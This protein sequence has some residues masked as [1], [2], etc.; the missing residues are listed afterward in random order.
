M[1]NTPETVITMLATSSLG[2]S[3]PPPAR[4]SDLPGCS[5]GS[6][7][8]LPKCLWQQTVMFYAGRRHDRREALQQIVAELPS[9]RQVYL[10][11]ELESGSP[12]DLRVPT[13]DFHDLLSGSG[14]TDGGFTQMP[15]DA[16]GFVLYPRV[17]PVCPSAWSTEVPVCCSNT[18]ASIA[19]TSTCARRSGVLVH[20]LRLDDVELAVSALAAGATVVLYDGSPFHPGPDHLW[21]I[22]EQEQIT[23]FGVSAK[24][25][26]AC[27]KQ[28][29]KPG[30]DRD[31]SSLRTIGSTGSPLSPEAFAY[32]YREVK[33][34]LHL[35]SI[36]GGTD[37]CGCFALGD[38]TSR[39]GPVNCRRQRSARTWTSWTKTETVCAAGRRHRGVDLPQRAAEYAP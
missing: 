2:P 1:P 37:I 6:G 34:D 16:P 25:L 12:V 38:P 32:V 35:A 29:L 14:T 31:L 5:T 4:T 36:S 19:G 28:G 15:F 8:S 17:P 20:H 21:R 3:S 13:H 7:R 11:G 33:P 10:V 26:D 9:V 30:E 24:Y 27:H 39:S 23:L 18:Q 22:A